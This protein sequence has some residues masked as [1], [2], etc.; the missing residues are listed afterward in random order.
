MALLGP[1]DEVILQAVRAWLRGSGGGLTTSQVIPLDADGGRPPVPYLAVG[2]FADRPGAGGLTVPGLIDDLDDDDEPQRAVSMR[3][4]VT[5]TVQAH[6][7][8]AGEW[9]REA[10]LR[11]ALDSVTGALAAAGLVIVP[12]GSGSPSVIDRG[13]NR[14]FRAVFDFEARYRAS[15]TPESLTAADSVDLSLS[16]RHRDDDS[17]L[18]TV[19][20]SIPL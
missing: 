11:L 18:A 8:L 20:T 1:T 15:T 2:V 13:T 5:I 10:D 4:D 19:T 3:R 9:V 6:G 14:E 17:D 7:R 12:G 16:L